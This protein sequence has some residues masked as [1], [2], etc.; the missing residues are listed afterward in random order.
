ME[1]YA[2]QTLSEGI[3]N[4]DDI[5]VSVDSEMYRVINLHYSRNNHIEVS[6]PPPPNTA[7]SSIFTVPGIRNNNVDDGTRASGR[8]WLAVTS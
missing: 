5:H 4:P 6:V 7:L 1:K 3:K 2:R 8:G